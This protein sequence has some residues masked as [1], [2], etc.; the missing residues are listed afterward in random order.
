M[1][2]VLRGFPCLGHFPRRCAAGIEQAIHSP[3]DRILHPCT[4]WYARKLH[5]LGTPHQ[6]Q[7][8]MCFLVHHNPQCSCYPPF[9]PSMSNCAPHADTCS[10]CFYAH[11]Y[12]KNAT[13]DPTYGLAN[14]QHPTASV[15]EG[16]R[17][18]KNVYEALRNGPKW[19]STMYDVL[20]VVEQC[21]IVTCCAA[22]SISLSIL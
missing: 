2:H 20:L 18:M 21:H 6:S 5:V 10:F 16:E 3:H 9:V 19:N 7:V 15:R 8:C 4:E 14:H 17:W 22:V 1:A 12:S 11:P 13:S